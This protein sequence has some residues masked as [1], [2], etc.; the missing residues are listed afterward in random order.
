MKPSMRY[1]VLLSMLQLLFLPN[2][3]KS[4][5]K[6]KVCV[7]MLKARAAQTIPAPPAHTAHIVPRELL[8]PKRPLRWLNAEITNNIWLASRPLFTKEYEQ[9]HLRDN[10]FK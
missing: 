6:K 2:E 5:K 9:L 3:V 7:S 8:P 10:F 4:K 1:F